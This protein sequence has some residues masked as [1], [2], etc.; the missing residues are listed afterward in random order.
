MLTLGE[1][2]AACR[3][4]LGLSIRELAER[5][6]L[7]PAIIHKLEHG[8]RYPTLTT[9]EALST[10]MPCRAVIENGTTTLEVQQ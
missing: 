7:S 3:T 6:D 4:A 2:L 9:L 1:Q 10:G 5:C 8:D